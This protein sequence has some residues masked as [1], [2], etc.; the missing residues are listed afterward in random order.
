MV[1]IG[2]SVW[3]VGRS[4]WTS[5]TE[6]VCLFVR[7]AASAFSVF[8]ARGHTFRLYRGFDEGVQS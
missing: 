2:C 1:V 5:T 8:G 4:V 6:A 3:F 7:H